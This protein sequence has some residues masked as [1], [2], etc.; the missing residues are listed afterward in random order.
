MVSCFLLRSLLW[1]RFI[2]LCDPM[3]QPSK[4]QQKW[5][6]LCCLCTS[7]CIF[8][9]SLSLSDSEMSTSYTSVQSYPSNT[10]LLERMDVMAS[11][12]KPGPT[13]PSVVPSGLSFTKSLVTQSGPSIVILELYKKLLLLWTC[14]YLLVKSFE[15]IFFHRTLIVGIWKSYLT[16]INL[17]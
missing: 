17:S 11:Y 7:L 8:H 2:K 5:G 15:C 16:P 4:N 13:F 3:I 12:I 9:I 14:F 6:M 10:E 1:L